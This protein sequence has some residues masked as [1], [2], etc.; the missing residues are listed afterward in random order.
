MPLSKSSFSSVHQSKPLF[1]PELHFR[2][3]VPAFEFSCS[4]AGLKWRSTGKDGV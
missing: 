2:L 1:L 4:R 3:Q